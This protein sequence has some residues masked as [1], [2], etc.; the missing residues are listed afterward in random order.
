VQAAKVQAEAQLA[1][2]QLEFDKQ[3]FMAEEQ[4]KREELQQD[5]ML[6][7]AEMEAKYGTQIDIAHLKEASAH[8]MQMHKSVTDTVARLHEKTLGAA[9]G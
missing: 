1:M 2:A 7:L 9:N 5:T 6:K 8:E 3:K 4:R